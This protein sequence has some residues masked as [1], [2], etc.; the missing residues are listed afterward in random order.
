MKKII[1]YS[2][3]FLLVMLPIKN[4]GVDQSCK[5]SLCLLIETDKQAYL[6]GDKI[7]LDLKIINMSKN[8]YFVYRVL[9]PNQSLDFVITDSRGK[10][11]VDNTLEMILGNGYLNDYCLLDINQYFGERFNLTSGFIRYKLNRG[12]YKIKVVY[13]VYQKDIDELFSNLKR[14]GINRKDK[15]IFW[16]GKLASNE[17]KITVK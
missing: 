1:I 12:D 9:Y 4:G 17:I 10:L 8:S 11:M 5:E 15:E 3:F 2:L 14:N 7:V 6:Y 13:T 16:S